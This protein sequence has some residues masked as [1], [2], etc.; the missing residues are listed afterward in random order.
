MKVVLFC[1]GLGMRLREYSDRIPKPL[2]EIGSRPLLWHLMKY[3]SHFGFKD[4]VLCLGYGAA[5]I[6]SYFVNYSEYVSNDFVL[7]EGGRKLELLQSDIQDWKITFADTG[8]HSNIGQRLVAAKKHL[9]GEEVFL[10]NYADGLC[11]LDLRKHVDEFLSRGKIASFL[12]VAVPQSYHVIQ[13]DPEGYALQLDPIAK[14]GIRING[15]FFAFRKQI[16]DFIQPGEELVMEPFKRLIE[17]RE[18][19]AMPTRA[20]G[21]AWIRSRTRSSS[22]IS[23]RAVSRRGKSGCVESCAAHQQ[24][25]PI[26]TV[27]VALSATTSDVLPRAR[28]SHV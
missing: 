27:S 8:T 6:K 7:S 2:A 16:F 13:A 14:S 1:G 24:R 23:S 12:S 9:D 18:L 5:A 17:R 26:V 15:G 10:A 3:Y 20:S 21:A 22:T 25:D 11:D 28:R 4:F 19:L